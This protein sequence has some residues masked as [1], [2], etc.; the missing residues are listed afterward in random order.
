MKN[1]LYRGKLSVGIAV[2][3]SAFLTL[4]TAFPQTA[5]AA[6]AD[7]AEEITVDETEAEEEVLPEG[8][9]FQGLRIPGAVLHFQ[10]I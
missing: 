9:A 1:R 6:E 2:A 5:L 3:L 7:P 4:G 8:D 10:H